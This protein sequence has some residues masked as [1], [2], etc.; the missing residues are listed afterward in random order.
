MELPGFAQ[1]PPSGSVS[2]AY[3]GTLVPF[4]KQG[5]GSDARHGQI[6]KTRVNA[7]HFFPLAFFHIERD[8]QGNEPFALFSEEFGSLQ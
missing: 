6:P 2:S 1:L 8:R 7:H 4:E 5:P 3:V